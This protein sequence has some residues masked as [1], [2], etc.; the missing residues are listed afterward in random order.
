VCG[1]TQIGGQKTRKRNGSRLTKKGVH[2]GVRET[3]RRRK[4][5]SLK[6][7]YAH[8]EREKKSQNGKGKEKEGQSL[9][10][11][12]EP[13]LQRGPARRVAKKEIVRERIMQ[14]A[15]QGAEGVE[16]REGAWGPKMRAHK[17][18][19]GEKDYSRPK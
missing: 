3:A 1:P 8:R 15:P 2:K 9:P 16:R 18:L 12:R 11:G 14:T 5:T 17:I 10:L 13:R 6:W 4:K 19:L 7:R